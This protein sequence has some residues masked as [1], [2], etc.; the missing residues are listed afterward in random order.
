[1]PRSISKGKLVTLPGIWFLDTVIFFRFFH[2]VSNHDAPCDVSFR[3]D[4]FFSLLMLCCISLLSFAKLPDNHLDNS[5][6]CCPVIV[7][8]IG[9]LPLSS[10]R[11]I[12]IDP[13]LK[14]FSKSKTSRY[15]CPSI[16]SAK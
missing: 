13:S 3:T 12:A 9:I 5:C 6:N 10:H 16:K 7:A 15:V 2:L 14:L 11:I 8:C 4:L 1:L